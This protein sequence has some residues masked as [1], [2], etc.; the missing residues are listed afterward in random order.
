MVLLAEIACAI[1]ADIAPFPRAKSVVF[2]RCA[3]CCGFAPPTVPR[4]QKPRFLPAAQINAA[5][6]S[7]E[8][9]AGDFSQIK[10]PAS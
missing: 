3:R 4:R 8:I 2:A 1:S 7:A 9:A 10:E 5:L 6:N